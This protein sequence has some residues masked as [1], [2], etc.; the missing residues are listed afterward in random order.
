MT[1]SSG[2]ALGHKAR[3]PLSDLAAN[4]TA[5]QRVVYR[6]HL[7]SARVRTGRGR[8]PP[9]GQQIALGGR[10]SGFDSK[11]FFHPVG[12]DGGPHP[13]NVG[14]TK[15]RASP[16]AG[17]PSYDVAHGKRGEERMTLRHLPQGVDRVGRELQR[18]SSGGQ[19][20][21]HGFRGGLETER[22]ERHAVEDARDRF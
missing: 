1:P 22:A 15:R 10:A 4:E 3:A 12:R 13:V 8:R 20:F 19:R 9:A 21:L 7:A 17:F 6:L 2:F 11:A 16:G 14:V 18:D 5:E